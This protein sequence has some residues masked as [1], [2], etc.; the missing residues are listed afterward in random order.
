M[1]HT[2]LFRNM[3]LAFVSAAL[4]VGMQVAVAQDGGDKYAQ[5]LAD[6]DTLTRYSEQLQRNVKAQEEQLTAIQAQVAALDATGAEIM[7]LINK[8]YEELQAFVASDL[9]F[10]DPSQASPDHRADRMAKLRDL[11]ANQ[12]AK[13]SEKFRRLLEAC[14]IEIEYGRT[15]ASYKGKLADGRDANFV[16]IGRITLM[17]RTE[18]GNETGYWDAQQKQWVVDEDY[19]EAV[20]DALKMAA[21][22]KAP[23]LLIVPVPAPQEVRS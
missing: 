9:P 1:R 17:Y 4:T 20:E 11:M 8:M 15:M 2:Q 3:R 12:S 6:A 23:D 13:P 10:I 14:Q 16:R 5:V 21:K 18:D 7:P 19:A 22:T